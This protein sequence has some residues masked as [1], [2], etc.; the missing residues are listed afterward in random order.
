M[1]TTFLMWSVLKLAAWSTGI[2]K[3]YTV[4]RICGPPYEASNFC[5]I[6]LVL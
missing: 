5:W 6:E 4:H 3:E 2:L 1:N